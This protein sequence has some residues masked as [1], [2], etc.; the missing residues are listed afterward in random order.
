MDFP[1]QEMTVK[2][3]VERKWQE[4]GEKLVEVAVWTEN[5]EGKLTTPGKAVVIFK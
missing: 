5:A 2:G 4:G 1:D 3:V